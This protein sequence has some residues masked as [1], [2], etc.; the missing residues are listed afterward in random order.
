LL[1]SAPLGLFGCADRAV[2]VQVRSLEA[3]GDVTFVCRTSDGESLPVREC[4]L[5]SMGRGERNLF[6]LVT[7]KSTG[8]VAV[9]NVPYNPGALASDEGVVDLDPWTPSFGFARI[10]ARPVDIVSTPGGRASFVGVAEPGRPGLFALP[11]SC[12]DT[13]TQDELPR[14]LTT[15]PACSLPAAPASLAV[16]IDPPAADGSIASSCDRSLGVEGEPPGA[17]RSQCPASLVDEPGPLG[18]RK[19]IVS[20]PDR[21]SLVVIDAQAVLDREPGTFEPCPIEVEL[22]LAVDLEGAAPE[23]VETPAGESCA[24]PPPPPLDTVYTPRPTGLALEAGTLYVAD[25]GAPVIHVVNVSNACTPMEGPPLLPRAA[26]RPDRVVTTSRVA[27]SPLT[28]SG[29]RFV[30]A[31]DDT[32]A[33]NASVM[34]FD[35]SPGS[36]DRTPIQHTDVTASPVAQPDR[37]MFGA[38]ARDLTFILRDEPVFDANGIARIGELCDPDPA[39]SSPG[40]AY[41]PSSAGGAAPS[42]LRGV[43][44]MVLLTNGEIATIDV[45]DFDAPCRRP[46]TA[47]PSPEEDFRGCANDPEGIERYTLPNGAPT[48]TGEVSCDVVEPHRPRSGRRMLTGG[49]AGTQ[50][51]SLRAF[52]QLAVPESVV[53]TSFQER[54][55]LLAV[56]FPTAPARVFVGTTLRQ[57]RVGDE[58]VAGELIIDPREAENYSL[59]LPWQ[60]PRAYPSSETVT[61]TYEGVITPE[62]PSG[63][64]T[65]DGTGG[66]ILEEPTAGLCDRGVLDPELAREVGVERFG[67]DGE[68][69]ETFARDHADYIVVTA[70]LLDDAD[71]YWSSAS[72]TFT[73]CRDVFGDLDDDEDENAEDDLPGTDE[74]L[75][76]REFRVV[77]AEQQRLS[78]EPRNTADPDR[79]A[80]LSRLAACCFPSGA[81][82]RVRASRQW[83]V[84]GSATGFRHGIVGTRVQTETGEWTVECAQGC[85][86]SLRL[87][88]SRVFEI[89]AESCSEQGPRAAEL[90]PVGLATPNDVCVLPEQGPVALDGPGAACIHATPTARFAVYRGAQPSRR[91]MQFIWQVAGGFLPLTLDLG[92]VS[93]AIL[94]ERIVSLPQLDRLGVVD[95]ASLGLA[96]FR[97]DRLTVI[98]PT[99]N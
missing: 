76:T 16:A 57:H 42:E 75:P 37:V 89:A 99:L 34:A 44:A 11:T 38:P 10:G 20:L 18:R 36:T 35:V 71:G 65:E 14:D 62:L 52:P 73:E 92:V 61:L 95:A 33:P 93:S 50:A 22:P 17:M 86:T 88:E 96:F 25:E 40:V 6:A 84:V 7:Q 46:I 13:P 80:E 91:D 29:R 79:R 43:F 54:P 41:R 69:L 15:W 63:F 90:C 94:P 1:V 23:V 30:Y 48:V 55:K 67:L 58:A 49:S 32:D 83:V 70:D 12:L 45:E 4:N 87:D 26:A 5:D 98:T 77:D 31:I 3:S 24:A 9:I 74:L 8:E 39:S 19:L 28:P 59:A 64:L 60:E 2:T 47:N 81:S 68:A 66:L 78:V 72:C 21:G 82:Y 51:P 97:L 53:R 56:D 85:N 27:A